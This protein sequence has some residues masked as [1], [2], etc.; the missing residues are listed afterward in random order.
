MGKEEKTTADRAV[1]K[2]QKEADAIKTRTGVGFQH[3]A[4]R[5]LAGP[6]SSMLVKFCYQDELFAEKVEGTDKKLFDCLAEIIKLT[7]RD[8]PMISDLDAYI[9]A[10]QFY[11]PEGKVTMSCRIVIPVERDDDLFDL[12]VEDEDTEGEAIILELPMTE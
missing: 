12:G 11:F 2:L 4:M 6:V 9:K 10:V 7:S 5:S 3:I 8:K 1:E